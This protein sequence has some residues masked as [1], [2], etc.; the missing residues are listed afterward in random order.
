MQLLIRLFSLITDLPNDLPA[1]NVHLTRLFSLILSK[2]TYN[3][4]TKYISVNLSIA[5]ASFFLHI[6]TKKITF[7]GSLC[8]IFK[9]T[10]NFD[11]LSQ[12]HIIIYKKHTVCTVCFVFYFAFLSFFRSS[13]ISASNSSVVGFLFASACRF[14]SSSASACFLALSSM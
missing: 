13:T 4:L 8:H 9:Y 12:I 6:I 1:F 2:H 5:S 10:T 14:A 7:Q 11:K 3:Q